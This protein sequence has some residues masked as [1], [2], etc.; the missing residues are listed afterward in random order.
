MDIDL[1][2]Q[3][4]LIEAILSFNSEKS[5]VDYPAVIALVSGFIGVFSAWLTQ[6]SNSKSEEKRINK[7][8]EFKHIELEARKKE[9]IQIKQLNVLKELSQICHDIEPTVWPYP[10]YDS[11]DAYSEIFS[12]MN[13]I[14][15]QLDKFLSKN[16][17]IVPPDITRKI[18]EVMF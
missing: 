13:T 9:N 7:E 12:N 5:W 18:R 16:D 3:K 17:Y 10:N 11:Y 1:N 15:S 8:I 2:L 4:E 14:L 6:N